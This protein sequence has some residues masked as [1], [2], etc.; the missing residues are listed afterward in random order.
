MIA[1]HFPF[2]L[3]EWLLLKG[4]I[5]SSADVVHHLPTFTLDTIKTSQLTLFS[6]HRRQ[7]SNLVIAHQLLN[8]LAIISR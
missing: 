3:D 7:R 8:R 5:G 4:G 1:D 2:V 6:A